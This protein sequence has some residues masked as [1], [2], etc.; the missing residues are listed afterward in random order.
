[1]VSDNE[2]MQ[3]E[4]DLLRK[5]VSQVLRE[6]YHTR[7]DENPED[8][9]KRLEKLKEKAEKSDVMTDGTLDKLIREQKISSVMATS[10]AN[11]SEKHCPHFN[12]VDR[13]SRTALHR[14]RYAY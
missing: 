2:Y 9:L 3:K 6:I 7:K 14:S 4:Y 10:L 12:K 5:K 8:H 1:M 13:N 11:D